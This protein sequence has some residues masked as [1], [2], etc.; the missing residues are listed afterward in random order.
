MSTTTETITMSAIDLAYHLLC[1]LRWH[2][3]FG[4]DKGVE[5]ALSA[6]LL[7]RADDGYGL[8]E[9]GLKHYIEHREALRADCLAEG[10]EDDI[11]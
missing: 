2:L 1:A 6:G 5:E 3:D 10:Y 8:T 4:F 7:V 11:I 9:A